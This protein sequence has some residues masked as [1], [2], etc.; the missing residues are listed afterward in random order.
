MLH[1]G[2]L[3]WHPSGAQKPCV[4]FSEEQ[5]ESLP[6]SAELRWLCEQLWLARIQRLSSPER[7]AK[8]KKILALH[9]ACEGVQGV[10]F[11]AVAM[12]VRGR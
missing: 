6:L 7:P 9:N 10:I 11:L 1:F 4:S 2:V 5:L 3:V 12:R 8:K